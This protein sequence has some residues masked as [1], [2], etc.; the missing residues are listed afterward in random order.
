MRGKF[1]KIIS[2]ILLPIAIIAL[3]AYGVIFYLDHE[4]IKTVLAT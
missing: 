4:G 3:A 2:K 1:M